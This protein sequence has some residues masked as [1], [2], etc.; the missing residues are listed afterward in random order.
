MDISMPG[1][2][3]LDL[4]Q[5]L[6]ASEPPLPVV[7]VQHGYF[8]D[9][10]SPRI[11]E[12]V[13]RAEPDVLLVA[14][15]APRQ[16]IWIAEHLSEL[17]VPICIGVGGTFDVLAGRVKRAPKLWRRLGLEWLFRLLSEPS[18]IKRQTALPR[19]AW[20]VLKENRS[21]NRRPI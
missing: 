14:L 21:K 7:G 11:I 2:S 5:K 8:A 6:A 9:A 15:G 4:A 17:K 19:F 18:R 3:G 13:R 1:M 20:L 12:L 16:D 10:E